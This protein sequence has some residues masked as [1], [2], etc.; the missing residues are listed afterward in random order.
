MQV[1]S[2]QIV[3]G[4]AGF[5]DGA[6]RNAIPPTLLAMLILLALAAAAAGVPSVRRRVLARR[7]A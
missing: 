6:A 3:P 5:A 4:T 1:G 7:L 2:E